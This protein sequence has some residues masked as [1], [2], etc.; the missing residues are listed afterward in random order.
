MFIYEP[1]VRQTKVYVPEGYVAI[2][3]N[4]QFMLK[5]HASG[6]YIKRNGDKGFGDPFEVEEYL[7]ACQ[8]LMGE[9]VDH[10]YEERRLA[11]QVYLRKSPL[12][13]QHGD[14]EEENVG[15]YKLVDKADP[16][17]LREY[18]IRPRNLLYAIDQMVNTPD[19][20]LMKAPMR[21]MVPTFEG[22]TINRAG[23]KMG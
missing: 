4:N 10:G 3:L 1:P 5:R 16:G 18:Y 7:N 6:Y 8:A 14:G 11:G 22:G 21:T 13:I 15:I 20:L 19:A 2:L 12:V 23:S 9:A 17:A